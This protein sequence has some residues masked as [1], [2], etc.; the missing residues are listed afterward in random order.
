MII[1]CPFSKVSFYFPIALLLHVTFYNVT[2]HGSGDV[3]THRPL[4]FQP[5]TCPLC[6]I[7]LS[8]F[9]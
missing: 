1:L 4:P 3:T 5:V 7:Y 6:F 8:I 9:E 2:F